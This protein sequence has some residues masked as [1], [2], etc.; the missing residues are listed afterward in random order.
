MCSAILQGI[1]QANQVEDRSYPAYMTS[2]DCDSWY[3][4]GGVK[5]LRSLI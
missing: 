3:S 4:G 2:H 1:P 5:W